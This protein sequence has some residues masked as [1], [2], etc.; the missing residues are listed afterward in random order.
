MHKSQLLQS[1]KWNDRENNVTL[2]LLAYLHFR[3]GSQSRETM[4]L[5]PVKL[6][7][8]PLA[9]KYFSVSSVLLNASYKCSVLN[10]LV[11]ESCRLFLHG[12]SVCVCVCVCVC[13]RT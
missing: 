6:I 1:L 2:Y 9:V 4:M 8:S 12:H 10:S 5:D 7:E 13:V 3:N 11:T